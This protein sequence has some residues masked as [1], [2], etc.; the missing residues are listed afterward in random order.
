M[1]ANTTSG[2]GNAPVRDLKPQQVVGNIQAPDGP[3]IVVRVSSG[4]CDSA[5]SPKAANGELG[6]FEVDGTAYVVRRSKRI[7]EMPQGDLSRVLTV[8]EMEIA[9]LIAS[10]RANKQ[11]AAKLRISEHTVS[12]YLNRIYSKLRV[13]N[14]SSVAA[15]YAAWASGLPRT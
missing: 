5:Q 3:L 4:E 11:I 9:A 12:S 1:N 6:R 13:H 7:D 8:R 2:I 10:G 15:L 14:R